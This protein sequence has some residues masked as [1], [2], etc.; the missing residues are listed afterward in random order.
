MKWYDQIFKTVYKDPAQYSPKLETKLTNIFQENQ[1]K[2]ISTNEK[3]GIL[4]EAIR[5][6]P[7]KYS[8][9]ETY[10]LEN[11]FQFRTYRKVQYPLLIITECEEPQ[12][13][14]Y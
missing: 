13:Y 3:L 1:K 14:F 11:R 10:Y 6:H 2:I 4:E 12:K 9:A 5:D 8:D 7:G